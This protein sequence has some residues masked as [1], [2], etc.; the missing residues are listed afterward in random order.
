LSSILRAVKPLPPDLREIL[1]AGHGHGLDVLVLRFGALGDVLRT[2]PVVRVVRRALPQ[3]GIHWAIDERWAPL[4]ED[5]PDLDGILA[6]P[7]AAWDRAAGSP[8]GWPRLPGEIE[9]WRRRLRGLGAGLVLDFHGNLR[10]G[11]SGWLSGAPVRLGHA[12]HQ[13]KEG[14]RLLTTHRVPAGSRRT[15]RMER[16]LDLVRALGIDDRLPPD[17][18]LPI[19]TAARERAREIAG[20]RPCAVIAAGVSKRQGYKKPPAELL[21]AAAGALSESGIDPLVVW[22]PGE[23]EDAA[24]VVAASTGAARLAPPTGLDDLLALLAQARLFVGGDTGPMHMACAVGCPVVAL[25]GPTDPQVNAPWGVAH[26]AL[27]PPRNR[28]SGIKRRDRLQGFDGLSAETVRDAVG[29]L[30]VE[31]D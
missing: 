25:Y 18:A 5:H 20:E 19:P 7:R 9:G 11:L 12:G 30:L 31:R 6:F 24:A 15:P 3:A 21:A 22:G 23:E 27:S 4:L 10:S 16:N 26:A 17:A 13:Q 29:R 14:N 8:S 2:L 1:Q 28:Y